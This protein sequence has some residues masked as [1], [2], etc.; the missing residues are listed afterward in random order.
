MMTHRPSA[1]GVRGDQTRV[2]VSAQSW[3][4]DGARK[5]P[6]QNQRMLN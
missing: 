1:R 4:Q 6:F 5:K 2:N 3:L